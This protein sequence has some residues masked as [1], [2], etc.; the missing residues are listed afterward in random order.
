MLLRKETA[1]V[2]VTPVIIYTYAIDGKRIHIVEK[3]H[4]QPSPDQHC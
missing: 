1:M 3:R 2:G 4:N